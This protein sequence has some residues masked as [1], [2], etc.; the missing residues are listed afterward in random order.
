MI[1]DADDELRAAAGHLRLPAVPPEVSARLRQTFQRHLAVVSATLVND[2]RVGGQLVGA[3]GGGDSAWTLSYEAGRC[4]VLV[5][6][7]PDKDRFHLTGQLLCPDPMNGAVVRA[8]RLD[9]LVAAA[10]TDEVGQFDLDSL[11]PSVYTVAATTDHGI[12]ELVVD[13]RRTDPT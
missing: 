11:A 13:L 3:R 4:D 8:Y 5:D 2:S 1:G 7:A 12:V 6:V 9:E 10:S